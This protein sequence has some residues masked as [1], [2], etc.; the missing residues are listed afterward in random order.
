MLAYQL[1]K[2]CDDACFK[3]KIAE[4][5]KKQGYKEEPERDNE[6]WRRGK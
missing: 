6:D 4:E 3:A 2:P 1:E 5:V